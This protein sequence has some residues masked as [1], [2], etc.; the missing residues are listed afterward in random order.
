MYM[1]Y[2]HEYRGS[3]SSTTEYKTVAA[4]RTNFKHLLD[5][6]A[7][8]LPSHL[9][10]DEQHLAVVDAVRL[11][12]QLSASLPRAEVVAEEGGWSV[13][14]PG[15][16]VAADG[17]TY[18][19]AIEEMVAAL[20]EYAD[21]WTQRL[22]SAPNHAGNWGLVQVVSLSNDAQLARWVAGAAE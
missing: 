5:A 14:L 6:A 10:R 11:V 9:H 13:F 2:M 4:A 16:P 17:A 8:G 3:M 12:Q 18:T 22:H 15:V 21:D 20:R 19:E 1:M 7:T